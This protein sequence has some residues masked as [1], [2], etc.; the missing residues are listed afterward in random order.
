MAMMRLNYG[1]LED[2][3]I[4]FAIGLYICN[5]YVD[6]SFFFA[7]SDIYSINSLFTPSHLIQFC[8]CVWFYLNLILASKRACD[9]SRQVSLLL[10]LATKLS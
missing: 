4:Y 8:S 3:I 7:C 6:N 5:R 2:L 9:K 10:F 1:D